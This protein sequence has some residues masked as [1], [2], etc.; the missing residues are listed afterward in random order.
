M[1]KAAVRTTM[2]ISFL[3]IDKVADASLDTISRA[4]LPVLWNS[5]QIGLFGLK[6]FGAD[7][8]GKG[9]ADLGLPFES[10]PLPL[11]LPGFLTCLNWQS[12]PREQAPFV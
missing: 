7:R 5:R 1:R 9:E 10:L 11:P 2:A 8:L 6:G 3:E 12:L 4:H